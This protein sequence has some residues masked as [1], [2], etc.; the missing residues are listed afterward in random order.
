ME[1]TTP[2]LKYNP[3]DVRPSFRR[4]WCHEYELPSGKPS[5]FFQFPISTEEVLSLT[6]HI[7]DDKIS[8][9]AMTQYCINL[10]EVR[11]WVALRL[12]YGFSYLCRNR[13]QFWI[14][15]WKYDPYRSDEDKE[16][17]DKLLFEISSACDNVFEELSSRINNLKNTKEEKD[18]KKKFDTD[19]TTEETMV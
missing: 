12:K 18:F 4:K 1:S 2:K 7:S 19:L 14:D 17:Y 16:R 8:R 11:L 15:D 6:S 9:S 10:S 13:R 5:G 3:M